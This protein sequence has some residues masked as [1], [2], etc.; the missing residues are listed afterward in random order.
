[1]SIISLIEHSAWRLTSPRPLRAISWVLPCLCLLWS[2]APALAQARCTEPV[3]RIVSAEGQI[4]VR[5]VSTGLALT[6]SVGTQA[7]ICPGETI[8]AGRRSRAGVLLL[9]SNQIIRLDQNTSIRI[10]AQTPEQPRTLIDLLQGF[11]RLFNP[12]GRALDIR[13]PYVTAGTEGTEFYVS[14]D[15]QTEDTVA[16]VIDGIVRVSNGPDMLRLGPGEAVRV[17]RMGPAQR[18]N[19][20]PND[21]VRWAIYYPPAIW[22]L[23]P[24]EEAALDP[25][26]ARAWQAWRSGDFAG[27]ASALDAIPPQAALDARSGLRFAALL[28]TVGQVDEAAQAIDRAEQS[29]PQSPLI[30]ALR[31]VIAVAQNQTDAALTL[32]ERAHIVGRARRSNHGALL[33]PAERLPFA[34]SAAGSCAARIL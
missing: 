3:A 19:I 25:R 26:V 30:P 6:I 9:A 21:A 23:P 14:F 27:L 31:A 17:P 15:P 1:M 18:L 8:Q 24:Q 4:A 20:R 16:A 2:P 11:I 5:P 29:A 33:C 32:S 10:V 28:L 7:E 34:R 22:N 13:T 12:V